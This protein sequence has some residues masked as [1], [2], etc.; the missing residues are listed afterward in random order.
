ML[1]TSTNAK[2]ES[3]TDKVYLSLKSR[4]K[5]ENSYLNYAFI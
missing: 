4:T 5:Q 1:G 2:E 3:G